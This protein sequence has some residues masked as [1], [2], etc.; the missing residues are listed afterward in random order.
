M[1]R[2]HLAAAALALVLVL[3]GCGGGGSG[4][5]SG[6]EHPLGQKVVVK[7]TNPGATTA[8]TTLAIT[9]KAVRKGT[10][11]ELTSAGYTVDEDARDN[12]PYYVDVSYRNQGQSP[13]KKQLD[14]GLEDGDGNLIT[15]TVVFDFGGKPFAKCPRTFEGVLAPGKSYS[16]CTL[17]LVPPD[18]TPKRVSFLP[19]IPGKATDFVYWKTA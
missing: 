16:A 11:Q 3:A 10:M 14:V 7:T 8:P 5:G 17:F 15:S 9:V 18:K 19:S 4:G 1:Q 13:I 6:D 12:T 2:R